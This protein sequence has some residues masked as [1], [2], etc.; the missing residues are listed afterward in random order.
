MDFFAVNKEIPMLDAVTT[1]NLSSGELAG[2]VTVGVK[3]LGDL[4]GVFA[5]EAARA[6]LP[7]DA[8]VYTVHSHVAERDGTPGGLFFGTSFLNPGRVGDEYYMTRGH[9]HGRRETA[10]YYWCLRGEGIL[11]LM[12]ENRRCT[13]ERMTPGSLHYIPGHVAHRLVNTGD[14]ALTVGAC[15]PSDAG[16]DYHA[17]EEQGFSARVVLRGCRAVVVAVEDRI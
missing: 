15:W 10:E 9:F 16:H 2:D 8:V 17:I 6:S 7:Q 5:D 11:L 12:D 4:A 1:I 14:Q 3:R 13:P